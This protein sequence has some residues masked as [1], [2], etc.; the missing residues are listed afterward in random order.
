MSGGDAYRSSNM[1]AYQ[2]LMYQQTERADAVRDDADK[3]FCQA[4]LS[5]N[6]DDIRKAQED[7]DRADRFAEE[8]HLMDWDREAGM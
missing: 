3:A 5:G 2:K 8:E 7:A 6:L 1:N 4:V